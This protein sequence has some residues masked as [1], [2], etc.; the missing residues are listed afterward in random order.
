MHKRFDEYTH[1]V[2]QYVRHATGKEKAALRK[3]LNDHMADHAQAL[4]DGGYPEDHACRVAVESMGDPAEVGKAL[5]R[6]YPLRWL[7]LSRL[8]LV[9]AVCSLL[10]LLQVFPGGLYQ[11]M[12]AR[13]TPWNSGFQSA[14]LAE[15][16]LTYT[17]IK[18]EF[19]NGDVLW[20]YATAVTWDDTDGYTGHIYTSSYNRNPLRDPQ[21]GTYALTYTLKGSEEEFLHAGGGGGSS[22]GAAYMRQSFDGL[23]MGST[24]LA[25]Y[26]RHGTSFTIEIPLPWEEV[27]VP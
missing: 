22:Y 1:A 2:A 17:D 10:L 25:H 7:V 26:D 24:L 18:A 13:T 19:P 23:P 12:M 21:Y 5:N 11:S 16:Q 3:E 4:M 6:E 15:D 8:F 20:I 27:E 9:L 14:M